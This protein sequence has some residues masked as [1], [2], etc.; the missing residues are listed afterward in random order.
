MQERLHFLHGSACATSHRGLQA[1]LALVGPIAL[2]TQVSSTLA[3]AHEVAGRVGAIA[4]SQTII[5]R[6][7]CLKY[8]VHPLNFLGRV[9]L[10]P[11]RGCPSLLLPRFTCSRDC[12]TC[13]A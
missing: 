9:D 4:T 11:R 8:L 2:E 6:S 7:G 5:V 1:S 10:L 13:V 12:C 3:V